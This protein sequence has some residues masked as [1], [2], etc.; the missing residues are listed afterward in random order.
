MFY[1]ARFYDSQLGR[2]TSAD[3]IIPESQ[4]VQA[5]DRY[6]YVNNSPLR[7]TDPTGHRNC[8]EDGYHCAGWN[9]KPV[10]KPTKTPTPTSTPT[11]IPTPAPTSTVTPTLT[12]IIPTP[13]S[14]ST[15]TFYPTSTPTATTMSTPTNIPTPVGWTP[16]F[17]GDSDPIISAVKTAI[18]ETFSLKQGYAAPSFANNFAECA[19]AGAAP[20]GVAYFILSVYEG[21]TL[22][23]DGL[24]LI[25]TG[26]SNE[27]G[28]PYAPTATPTLF[29]STPTNTIAAPTPTSPFN[30]IP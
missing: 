14:M 21:V 2:F 10:V 4:G 11:F 27:P 22:G 5:W 19:R 7:Y 12:T 26:G 3:S 25:D 6:A 24:A 13:P 17:N 23:I 30:H 15:P 8:E 1:N 29:F 18:P 28:T 16:Q 20:C 9:Y